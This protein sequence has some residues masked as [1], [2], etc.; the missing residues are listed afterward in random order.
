[1]AS[2]EYRLFLDD[3]PATRDQ[4]NLVDEIAVEQ[5]IDMAW[6][7][8]LRIPLCADRKGKWTGSDAAIASSFT[9]V[10]VEIRVGGDSFVPLMDGPVVGT[11]SQMSTQPGQSWITVIVQDDSVHL[12]R[13]EEVIPFEDRRDDEVAADLFGRFPEIASTEIEATPAP[14]A[15]LPPVVVQ[16]GTAIKILRQLARRQGMHAFVLP[17]QNPGESV[18]VFKRLPREPE[19]L[20]PLVLLGANRN[21]DSFNVANDAQR[22]AQVQGWALNITDK[23]VATATSQ[24]RNLELLGDEAAFSSEDKTAIQ[25]LPPGADDSVDLN[26]RVQSA[27]DRSS[28]GFS[29]SGT[30]L[31]DCYPAVLFPYRVVSA[32]GVDAL[33][34]GNYV[35]KRVSHRLTRSTYSQT[36]DLLRNARSQ[37][38]DGALEDLAE[39]I[40]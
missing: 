37:T 12:N 22:P 20:P 39:A 9:R 34:T 19:G 30:V 25:L 8:R 6:E 38:T 1:M 26:Q 17:G 10:R 36:F 18:G 27:A 2:C 31:P 24:F 35:I 40:S 4:L 28:F 15:D 5:Q 21:V 32:R 16:R 13:A 23:S 3:E 11:D 14:T 7:A 33:L 29:A